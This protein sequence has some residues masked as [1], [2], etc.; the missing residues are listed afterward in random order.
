MFTTFLET[1]SGYFN[2]RLILSAFFPA[3]A[4]GGFNLLVY[5]ILQGSTDSI[6]LWLALP[7]EWQI[8]LSVLFFGIL[9]FVGYL[10]EAFSVSLTR[11]YEGYWENIPWLRARI[12]SRR[13][14]YQ[15]YWDYLKSEFKWFEEQITPL[16]D[17]AQ[18]PPPG[19]TSE[20]KRSCKAQIDRFYAEL[21]R[22]EREWFLFYP[23]RRALV[24]PTK[25]GNILR[26]AELYPLLRYNVDAVVTWPRLQSLLPEEFASGLR[27]AKASVDL[28]LNLTSTS[29]FRLPIC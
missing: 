28:L 22:Y 6:E 9:L 2:K 18:N 14:F 17:K 13:K 23:A 11:L 29:G 8:S 10:L 5:V 4:F 15:S 12:E 16:E 7:L 25:L 26:A 1:I 21:S 24:M 20:E 27:D 19:E 3:L